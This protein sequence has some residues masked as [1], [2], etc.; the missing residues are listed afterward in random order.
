MQISVQQA[1]VHACAVG[2]K[3]VL[4]QTPHSG[5]ILACNPCLPQ[6]A[7]CIAQ[8]EMLITVSVLALSIRTPSQQW[9]Q[10]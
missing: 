4:T 9:V 10:I 8:L 6:L 5:V 1:S 3:R 2:K 7:M